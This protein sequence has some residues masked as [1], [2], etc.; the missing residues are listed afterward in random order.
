MQVSV[1]PELAQYIEEQVKAGRYD[2]A[3]SAVNAAIERVRAEEELLAEDL[4]DED[5]AAIEEGLAQARRG[6]VRPW[7]EVRAELRARFI[8]NK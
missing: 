1:K 4:D 7:E 5:L 6:E 8:D 2:S 3:E